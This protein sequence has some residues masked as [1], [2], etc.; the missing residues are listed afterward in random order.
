MRA[1]YS[2]LGAQY[3]LYMLRK[4]V[5]SVNIPDDL[6]MAAQMSAPVNLSLFTIPTLYILI[7]YCLHKKKKEGYVLSWIQTI[8]WL[9]SIFAFILFFTIADIM[10]AGFIALNILW[11]AVC[12]ATFFVLMSP[13]VKEQFK[14]APSN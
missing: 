8:V 3:L 12:V 13:E 1:L 10:S 5:F 7:F 9:L 2:L 4:F 6:P 14:K 11:I